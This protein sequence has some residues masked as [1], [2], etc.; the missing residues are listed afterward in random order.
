MANGSAK[1]WAILELGL[2]MLDSEIIMYFL[3]GI[4][5]IGI[6]A[7]VFY[8]IGM[9]V[10][11]T[12]GVRKQLVRELMANGILEEADMTIRSTRRN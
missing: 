4:A 3:L 5:I 9:D 10:G 7:F 8:R 2:V 11:V 1:K 12:K 6:P